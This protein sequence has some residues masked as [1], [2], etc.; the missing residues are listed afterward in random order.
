MKERIIKL[1][2]RIISGLNSKSF[3]RVIDWV[4]EAGERDGLTHGYE[5]AAWVLRKYNAEFAD[6]ATYIVKT[7]VQIA[8]FIAKFRNLKT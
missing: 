4:L 1:V 6:K 2:I 8:Y 3:E 7:V 5:K